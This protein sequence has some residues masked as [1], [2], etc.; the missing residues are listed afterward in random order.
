LDCQGIRQK[1]CFSQKSARGVGHILHAPSPVFTSHTLSRYLTSPTLTS[2]LHSLQDVQAY[3]DGGYKR[4]FPCNAGSPCFTPVPVNDLNRR[5]IAKG[6]VTIILTL[7]PFSMP[8][9]QSLKVAALFN[10]KLANNRF[11]VNGIALIVLCP[12]RMRACSTTTKTLSIP[13]FS[14]VAL[15][16][17]FKILRS[18]IQTHTLHPQSPCRS[19]DCTT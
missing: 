11:I 10:K 5:T 1:A 19:K 4:G 13:H 2:D 9:A 14:F 17:V 3:N 15:C 12:R 18:I 16:L 8:V 6:S 7:P